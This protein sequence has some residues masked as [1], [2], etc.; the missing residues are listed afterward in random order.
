[1]ATVCRVVMEF[2]ILQ[3]YAVV[4]RCTSALPGETIALI[5]RLSSGASTGAIVPVRGSIASWLQEGKFANSQQQISMN[6]GPIR[7]KLS[8]GTLEDV[9]LMAIKAQL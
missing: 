3:W 6:T 4:A 1:M 8:Q 5:V 9:Y 2:E 7:V